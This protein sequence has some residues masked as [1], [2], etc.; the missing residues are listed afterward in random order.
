MRGRKK[1]QRS[2]GHHEV[3]HI[4]I[5]LESEELSQSQLGVF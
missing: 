1:R 3:Y 2:N 5:Q 4:S